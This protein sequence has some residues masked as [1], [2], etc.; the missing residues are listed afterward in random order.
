MW[1]KLLMLSAA[2]LLLIASG[3]HLSCRVS[4]DGRELEALYSPAV[5]RRATL[6]AERT[7]EE[8]CRE[9]ASMPEVERRWQISF[10]PANG[11]TKTLSDTL[12]KSSPEVMSACGVYVKNVRL[13]SVGSEKALRERL[14]RFIVGQQ[15]NWA[16]GGFIRDPIVARR[17][18]TREA[19]LTTLDDMALLISGMS[20]VLYFDD[21]GYIAR[22]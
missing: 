10:R 8:I 21:E 5:L 15:P 2:L 17:E 20:P 14:D 19:P 16:C 9:A 7:A 6:T 18:Y 3:L 11:D 22:A 12:L 1:K 13:G 4:I